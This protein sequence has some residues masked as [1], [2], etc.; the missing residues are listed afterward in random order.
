M[1]TETRTT[2]KMFMLV[3]VFAALATVAMTTMITNGTFAKV[4]AQ[5]GEEDCHTDGSTNCGGGQE[6]NNPD[7]F[8][9][10]IK[11]Q[12]YDSSSGTCIHKE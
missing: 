1:M 4:K 7:G 9:C 5:E 10:P 8:G 11:E 12:G 2:H 3:A 6:K